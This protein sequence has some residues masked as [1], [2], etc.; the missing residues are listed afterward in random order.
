MEKGFVI[1]VQE[2]NYNIEATHCFQHMHLEALV[3]KVIEH[4][5]KITSDQVVQMVNILTQRPFKSR[6]FSKLR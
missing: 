6:I 3:S 4:D 2:R 1:L 5:L